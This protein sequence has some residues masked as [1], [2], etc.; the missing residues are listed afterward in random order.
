MANLQGISE[1]L[2]V[3]NSDTVSELINQAL[4]ENI[5]PQKILEEGLI[6]GMSVVGEKFRTNVIYITQVLIAA[7]A[8]KIGME[9]LKPKLTET[10]VKNVGKAVMG[11][12]EGDLHDIGK[13]LVSMMLEGAG[14]EVIDLGSDV[15]TEQFV[16]AVK[17]HKP[18]IV[19]MSAMITTTMDNM[20]TVIKALEEDGLREKVKVMVGG[21]PVNQ[22]F[23]DKI[24]AD[25][26]ADDAVSAV[27]IAKTFI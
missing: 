16:E 2:Q 15:T 25:G 5:S 23:A 13:H 7:R 17:E 1:A 18:E 22:A 6:G 20:L 26:Y 14:F 4:N 21:A 12:V 24:G 9:I 8:M 3:G 10:G 27:D 11:T 19:G